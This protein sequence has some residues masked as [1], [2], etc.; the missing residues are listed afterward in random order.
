MKILQIHG[1]LI[2]T[3]NF[4]KWFGV[5]IDKLIFDFHIP[6][7]RNKVSMQLKVD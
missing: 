6:D 3:A 1:K 5:N 7:L 2:E 4:V